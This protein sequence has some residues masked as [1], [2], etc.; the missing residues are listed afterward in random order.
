METLSAGADFQQGRRLDWDEFHWQAHEQNFL[1]IPIPASEDVPL[2][3][4]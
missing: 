2:N 3:N 1:P 4:G